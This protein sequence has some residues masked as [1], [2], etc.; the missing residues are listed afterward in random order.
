M[1]P[2]GVRPISPDQQLA[3]FLANFDIS[4]A[5]KPAGPSNHPDGHWTTTCRTVFANR[6]TC[7]GKTTTPFCS[8]LLERE[9]GI[10]Y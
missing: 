1:A 6:T 2:I 4:D 7:S 8:L 10:C 3:N 5:A 9:D